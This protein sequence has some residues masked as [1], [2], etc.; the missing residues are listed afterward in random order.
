MAARACSKAVEAVNGEIRDAL[1]GLDA[2]DQRG[3]DQT[4]DRP[5]RHARTRS[6]S[7]P[8]P[9]S[10]CRWPS[11][12]RRPPRTGL[13]LY[14]YLG[15]AD[16]H[17]AA[18]ADDEHHQWRRAC[19]QPDRLPGIHDHAGRRAEHR[20]SRAHGRR[21]LPR[22]EE[23]AERRRPQHRCRR[24][25]RLRAQLAS[26]ARGARL[27]HGA[28]SRRPASSRARTSISR[29]MRGDRVLSRAARYVLEGERRSARPPSEMAAY[30]AELVA[31]YPIFS[32]EDG[33]AEDDWDGWK[34]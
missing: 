33:M 13:P 7:A 1:S 10:A 31:S 15:G 23:G 34:C 24:R 5:R 30:L 25:G 16:A 12:R 6:G 3:L 26:H 27:R 17:A 21:D 2:E 20:R 22:A 11:P 19:R 9:F 28:R 18:G 8:T 4:H 29:S 14:R 32:I